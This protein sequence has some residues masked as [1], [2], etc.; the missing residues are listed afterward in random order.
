M[1]GYMVG[2]LKSSFSQI[3]SGKSVLLTGSTGFLAKVFLEKILR[4]GP[5]VDKIYLLIRS[6]DYEHSLSRL[7]NDIFSSPLFATLYSQFNV[8]GENTFLNLLREK[9][10]FVSGDTS[11]PRMGLS[12]EDYVMLLSKVDYVVNS[13]ASTDFMNPLDEAVATNTLS[14]K[15][16]VQFIKASEKARLLHVSTCYIHESQIDLVSESAPQIPIKSKGKFALHENGTVNTSK[17]LTQLDALVQKLNSKTYHSKD[18]RREAFVQAGYQFAQSHGWFNIYTFTKWLGESILQENKDKIFCSVI[19]PSIVESCLYEPFAGWIEGLKVA[20]PLIYGVGMN[21]IPF[22]PGS[23]STILDL[24]PVDVVSNAMFLGLIEV[25]QKTQ[26]GVAIYQACSG[27]QKPLDLGLVTDIVRSSFDSKPTFHRVMLP[28]PLFWF[29]THSLLTAKKISDSLQAVFG[30]KIKKNIKSVQRML[31]LASIYQPYTNIRCR[32]DN[33]NLLDLQKRV[34]Q[35]DQMMFPVSLANLDWK[36]YLG[37]V[38]IPGLKKFVVDS[39]SGLPLNLTLQA[40]KI[41]ESQLNKKV[42]T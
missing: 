6:K 19:R 11:K 42:G 20:D 18:E 16:I 21:K 34:V 23:H 24:V 7:E 9:I 33:E 5:Q 22:F 10:R 32:F 30:K 12:N 27:G 36:H 14:V 3:I 35:Q 40:Q 28:S 8:N 38:H 4:V 2:N 41:V 37:Q 15:N 39:R 26:P 29:I 1:V 17:V 25:A 13:A 31:Q